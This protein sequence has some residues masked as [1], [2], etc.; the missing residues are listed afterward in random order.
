MRFH[1]HCSHFGRKTAKTYG[2][3]IENDDRRNFSQKSCFSSQ[4]FSRHLEC[5]IDRPAGKFLMSFWKFLLKARLWQ[6][7]SY[8]FE[9]IVLPAKIPSDQELG[10]FDITAEVFPPNFSKSFCLKSKNKNNSVDFASFFPK[11][12]CWTRWKQFWQLNR[13]FFVKNTISLAHW[14]KMI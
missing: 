6:K 10:R 14:P 8:F 1:N 5:S 12:L 7:S 13:I 2:S 11:F 3:K 4:F 9:K